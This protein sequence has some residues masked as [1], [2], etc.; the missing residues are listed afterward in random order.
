VSR[1]SGRVAALRHGGQRGAGRSRPSW[2][3]AA[4]S[5][6]RV[7]VLATL[8]VLA[9][10]LVFPRF[11]G[12]NATVMSLATEALTY[13]LVTMSLNLLMGY[14]GQV[15]VGQAGFLAV[16]AYT[17]AIVA[18]RF[19]GLPFIV[20]LALAGL[21]TAAVGLVL[22]LPAARL[23]GHYLAVATLGFGL[24]VP[25]IALNGGSLTG[26]YT[27]LIVP[28]QHLGSV[29]LNNPV[30]VYYLGLAVLLVSAAAIRSVLASPT[31]RR[32]M[33]VRDSQDTAPAMGIN[34]G[35]TKVI[36]FTL[37]AF[38]CGLAGYV[39][40]LNNSIVE[41]SSFDFSLSLFFFAAVIVGG[42]GSMWGS[43]IAA[44]LLVVIQQEAVSLGGFSEAILGVAVV[45]VLLLVPGG[46]ASL[47]RRTRDAIAGPRLLR[48]PPGPA[49]TGPGGLPD[50][51]S[52]PSSPAG[53]SREG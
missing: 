21:V 16:G 36:L 30:P 41:Y 19:G 49:G 8:V 45:V 35:R 2:A 34:T 43:L 6:A 23:R 9:V 14:G 33:A 4:R 15:S 29:M 1:R 47:G 10:A 25:E 22:G 17:T 50:Q 42:L 44:A 48:R 37:S 28:P 51:R 18:T 13:G 27:G 52:A 31:G 39:F 53:A 40:A 20:V 7:P 3:A 32:F 38:F 24:A 11:E 12:G 26:G 5:V 46:L